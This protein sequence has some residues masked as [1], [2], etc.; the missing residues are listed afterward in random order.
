MPITEATTTT[1]T[2]TTT[3]SST[4]PL[5]GN[6]KRIQSCKDVGGEKKR[7]GHKREDDFKTQYNPTSLNEP[8]EY[9]ATSDTW[10]PSGLDI[11]KVLCEHFGMGESKDLYFSNKSGNNIQFT[12]GQIPELSA[13]DNLQWIQNAANSRALFSKYLKKVESTRPADI[14]VYKDNTAHKWVFF[15]MDDIIN[16]IVT[17]A[18]WRK[19]E[20]GR[21]K[22]DFD[23]DSKKGTAQY[24]TYEYR[25]NQKRYFLGLNGGKGIEFIHL[26]K[27]NIIFYEDNF[28]YQ[29]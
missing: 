29:K 15:K 16:F 11:S 22:G 28:N 23:N 26:L 21:I 27:K 9:K 20:S 8:T 24:L 2:T 6:A 4:I 25:T 5:T 17:K 12:L 14:L 7:K 10:I 1:T 18:T 13:E 3:S 19:L